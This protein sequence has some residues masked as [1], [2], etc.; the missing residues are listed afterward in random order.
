MNEPRDPKGY[1]ALI[2]PDT[3]RM[4]LTLAYIPMTG[5]SDYKEACP[6]KPVDMTSRLELAAIELKRQG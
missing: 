5:D 3:G 1:T 2:N 6:K 4:E